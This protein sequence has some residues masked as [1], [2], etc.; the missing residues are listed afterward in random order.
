VHRGDGCDVSGG[1]QGRHFVVRH[2]AKKMNRIL[3]AG[4]VRPR[5]QRRFEIPVTRNRNLD[6]GISRAQNRRGIE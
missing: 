3:Q 1:E 5:P 2:H 6:S 4:G